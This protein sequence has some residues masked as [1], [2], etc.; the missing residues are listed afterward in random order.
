MIEEMLSDLE[1][2]SSKSEKRLADLKVRLDKATSVT[3]P[4]IAEWVVDE[5]RNLNHLMD[6]RK[7]LMSMIRKNAS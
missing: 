1:V 5:E 7:A 2:T 6:Q 3:Y 4:V